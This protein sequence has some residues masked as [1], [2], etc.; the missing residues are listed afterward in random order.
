M[1]D[2]PHREFPVACQRRKQDEIPT[3]NH[4]EAIAQVLDCIIL[5]HIQAQPPRTPE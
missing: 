5:R 2:E 3:Q 4:S 1:T